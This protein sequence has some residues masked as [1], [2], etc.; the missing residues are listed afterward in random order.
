MLV[1]LSRVVPTSKLSSSNPPRWGRLG[2]G[3]GGDLSLA[4]VRSSDV[5]APAAHASLSSM[6]SSTSPQGR[7]ETGGCDLSG[8]AELE[9][10]TPLRR[11][12]PV[13]PIR[14]AK[15]R[16]LKDRMVWIEGARSDHEKERTGR[17]KGHTPDRGDQDRLV[18][19]LGQCEDS[20]CQSRC[21]GPPSGSRITS[22][23]KRD[24][25]H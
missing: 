21:S 13:H 23:A 7:R 3:I 12:C 14:G 19:L 24:G 4:G 22:D 5:R 18:V 10:R 6:P 16:I 20:L 17:E 8:D 25:S 15:K 1:V 9:G 11:S 2:F